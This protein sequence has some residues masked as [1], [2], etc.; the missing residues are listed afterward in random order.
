MAN[1]LIKRRQTMRYVFALIAVSLLAGCTLS[2]SP[3]GWTTWIEKNR[4]EHGG[5][6]HDR[7]PAQAPHFH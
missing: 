2:E 7:A 6:R 4:G 5:D 1:S 3:D